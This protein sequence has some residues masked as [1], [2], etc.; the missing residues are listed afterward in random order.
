MHAYK[1]PI[2]DLFFVMTE[3]ADLKKYAKIT[4]NLDIEPEYIKTILEEADKFAANILAPINNQGDKE[5]VKLENG[6]IRMPESFKKAYKQF[7]KSGWS[8]VLGD[9]KY[10]GQNLPWSVII[11]LNELWEAA[12]MSFA[13]NLMLTQGAIELLN[14][15]GTSSQK[16][17]YLPKMISGEWTG[18]MNLTEPQAG[19]D[20]SNIKT[21]AIPSNNCYKI[22]GNK[23]YI[24]H[25]DQD[26]S[27][28]IIHLV[29]AR[30]P[31]APKGVRGIS[32]FL[33]PKN[34]VNED[35]SLKKND[36]RVVSSEHKLGLM[37]SPTCVLAYGDN[38]G[39]IGELIGNPNEGLKVM[40]AMMN[41]ARLNVGLQGVAIA[42]RAYQ[43]ALSFSHERMQGTSVENSSSEIVNIIKHPDVK[44]MLMEMKSQIEAMRGLT[45]IGAEALDLSLNHPDEELATNNHKLISLLTPVIKSWCTD[46]AVIIASLGVQVHGGMGFIEDTGAAQ[47]YRDAR[48]LPIYEGTNGIQA[49]DLLR[50]KLPADDGK[51]FDDLILKVLKT[52]EECIK[53]KNE[54][55]KKI[56]KNLKSCTTNLLEAAKWL[57]YNIKNDFKTSAAGATPFCNMLGWTLGGWVLARSALKS[58]KLIEENKNILFSKA[59][60]ETASFYSSTYLPMASAMKSTILESYKYI[61]TIN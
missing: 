40:F 13:V 32:L 9:K 25:G 19:S 27:D 38:E 41:N 51:I 39:A 5:G 24:T 6:L 2:E 22:Y 3:L 28:N 59:K 10:G 43:K 34:I 52:S 31:D 57:K 26:M 48:I 21:K 49:L 54:E 14:E 47:Y 17:K 12:N 18:T 8:T 45:I 50:R 44:R 42:E 4:N 16:N 55:I 1:A 36:I 37:A 23:I 29:L 60:I 7:I 56:G 20:L 53:S 30:L 15:H 33:V 35:N 46:Q 58:L 61:N 11:A